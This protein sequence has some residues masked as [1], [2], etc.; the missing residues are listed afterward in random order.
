MRDLDK[1]LCALLNGALVMITANAEF[2][3]G[4]SNANA[5]QHAFK[6]L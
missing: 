5:E 6:A 3:E 4:W 2:I 1:G